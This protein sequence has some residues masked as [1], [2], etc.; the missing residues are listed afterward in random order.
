MTAVA[1]HDGR[2]TEDIAAAVGASSVLIA[3]VL[4]SERIRGHVVRDADGTWRAT[5]KLL[6]R[7]APA[8]RALDGWPHA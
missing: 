2:T 1:A 7:H 8:F 4:K 5:P 3:Q 6:R